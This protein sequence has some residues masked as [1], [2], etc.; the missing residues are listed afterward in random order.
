[1]SAGCPGAFG[2]SRGKFREHPGKIGKVYPKSRNWTAPEAK[3][4]LRPVIRIFC[5]LPSAFSALTA[6]SCDDFP[7]IPFLAYGYREDP[8]FPH[9][10]R[11]GPGRPEFP[12]VE[13]PTDLLYVDQD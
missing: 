9:F 10:P 5:V 12:N 13:N 1:M 7:E 11:F 8:H 4:F 2:G 6:L 3:Q